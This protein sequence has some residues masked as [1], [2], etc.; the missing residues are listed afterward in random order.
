MN[1]EHR[2]EVVIKIENSLYRAHCPEFPK[3]S[4]LGATQE[5][6][7]QKLSAS[8][9]RLIGKLARN[10]I[11]TLFLSDNYTQVLFDSSDINQQQVRVFTVTPMPPSSQRRVALMLHSLHDL[12]ANKKLTRNEDMPHLNSNAVYGHV[13][14][15]NPLAAFSPTNLSSGKES[16]ILGFPLSIN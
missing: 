9:G 12:L 5:E 11:Q 3:C 1:F 6:A 2:L 13:V 8:I 14:I 10:S 16:F 15:E 4:G 7:L